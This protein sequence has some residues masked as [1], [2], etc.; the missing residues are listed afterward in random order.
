MIRTSILRGSL[1]LVLAA[2]WALAA[3]GESGQMAVKNGYGIEVSVDARW[4]NGFGYRPIRIEVRPTAAVTQPRQ[5]RFEI[6]F[7]GER[8]PRESGD[9]KVVQ[10][11]DL[12][13][14]ASGSRAVVSAPPLFACDYRVRVFENGEELSLLAQPWS[15][16]YNWQEQ[17]VEGIPRLLVVAAAPPNFDGLVDSLATRNSRP[18]LTPGS[19]SGPMGRIGIPGEPQLLWSAI[20]R[21][22]ESL[23]D[24]WLDLTSFDLVAISVDDLKNLQQRKPQTAAAVRRWTAAGGNL[25]I[26]GVG[27]QW[28]RLE[29][30]ERL[31]GWGREAGAADPT[32]NEPKPEDYEK[33]LFQTGAVAVPVVPI[34]S[35][36]LSPGLSVDYSKIE[37]EIPR[38]RT[39]PSR[40]PFKS[41][42]YKLGMV[43]VLAAVDPPLAN[44]SEWTWLLNTLGADRVLW[45][46]RHGVSLVSRNTDFWDFSIP[47][48]GLPPVTSFEIILTLFVLA[49][50]P[51]NYFLLRRWKRLHLLIVTVPLSAAVV[52]AALFGYALLSDGLG[53][54]V[55]LRSL[56]LL[57]QRE[58]QAIVWARQAYYAG[59]SPGGGLTFPADAMVV[60]IELEPQGGMS[61]TRVL[62]WTDQQRLLSGWLPSRTPTQFLTVRATPSAAAAAV[63]TTPGGRSLRNALGTRI[64]QV[65]VRLE[66]GDC[67]RAGEIAEGQ[68]GPLEKV[69]AEQALQSLRVLYRDA[70]LDGSGPG[71]T[72]GATRRAMRARPPGQMAA[73]TSQKS[74]RLEA[75]LTAIGMSGSPDAV[76]RPGSYIA[77]V[78]RPA[79]VVAGTD[80]KEEG[81][82]HI[83]V[84]RW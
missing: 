73:S 76:L 1:A 48:V 25:L 83:I 22:P 26:L 67:Y 8:G 29:E 84:G 82:F 20:V 30:V 59:L 24:Q 17:P 51:A 49:I 79:E 75:E 70:Q 10:M 56:T 11:L 54:R 55:R 13:V 15:S 18:G 2:A 34:P 72:P 7:R 64:L 63:E 3:R 5:L 74:S 6:E 60:P 40:A 61:R 9:L 45:Q 57:D 80:A 38:Q 53:A 50:G 19:V 32:W 35:P 81:G 44:G 31:V 33:M 28:E 43:T 58:G 21:S 4:V 77:V 66:N 78:E 47:G 52:T 46:Q 41:R 69:P 16:L 27:T 14:G 42:P 23:T 71:V 36:M 39:R 65:A 68:S 37:T 12:D 62:Q